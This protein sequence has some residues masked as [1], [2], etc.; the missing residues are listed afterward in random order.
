MSHNHPGSGNAKDRRNP[1]I[2]AAWIGA[3]AVVVA[4]LITA[5]FHSGHGT[6]PTP[7]ATTTVA[8]T[9]ASGTPASPTPTRTTSSQASPASPSVFYTGRRQLSA[10][11]A[12]YLDNPTWAVAPVTSAPSGADIYL[13]GSGNLSRYDGEWGILNSPSGNG[14]QQCVSFTAF[15]ASPVPVAS[16]GAGTRLCVRTSQGRVGL[17]IV[18]GISGQGFN[19]VITFDV[20]VWNKQ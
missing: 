2:T 13:D 19:E 10:T 5:V 12:A 16:L 18:R 8:G 7:S 14:Y 17:L 9:A 3:A 1:A 4:A 15:A 6:S 11:F 20:T